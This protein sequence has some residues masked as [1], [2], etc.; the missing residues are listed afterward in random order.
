MSD[1]KRDLLLAELRE[2]AGD[3]AAE[4]GARALRERPAGEGSPPARVPVGPALG[5][6]LALAA[7]LLLGVLL[8]GMWWLPVLLV[9]V[10]AL[11]TAVV[12]ATFGRLS[13]VEAPDPAVSARLEALGVAA[14]ERELNDL[15]ERAEGREPGRRVRRLFGEDAGELEPASGDAERSAAD[16]QV[17]WTPSS[18]ATRPAG[19]DRDGPGESRS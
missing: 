2:A 14:P 6:G 10:L 18:G 11:A 12:T 4:R 19:A 17:A 5:A 15:I 8:G 7:G 16:Q 9:L 13:Q 1:P 3:D